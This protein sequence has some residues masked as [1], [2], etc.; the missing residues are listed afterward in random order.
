LTII[1]AKPIGLGTGNVHVPTGR[2]T[3]VCLNESCEAEDHK[4][5]NDGLETEDLDT[6]CPEGKTRSFETCHVRLD[7]K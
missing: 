7:T 4:E 6:T 1:K 5:I 2:V 3:K